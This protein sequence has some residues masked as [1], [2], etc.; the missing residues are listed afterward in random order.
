MNSLE[1]LMKATLAHWPIKM[2]RTEWQDK[3]GE[4]GMSGPNVQFRVVKV[5]R[6]DRG[7]ALLKICPFAL[8]QAQMWFTATLIL[9]F[10]E[11]QSSFPDRPYS[12]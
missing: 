6:K 5:F 12:F 9:V 3:S 1:S 11:A 2:H 10:C 7:I 8:A 4:N